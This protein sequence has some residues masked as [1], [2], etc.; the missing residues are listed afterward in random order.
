MKMYYMDTAGTVYPDNPHMK[1][2]PDVRRVTEEEA[3]PERFIPK[4]RA[5]AARKRPASKKI[6]LSTELPEDPPEGVVLA[7]AKPFD[8]K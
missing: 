1:D 2:N 7:A 5:A 6:D 3:F 4:K 8:A